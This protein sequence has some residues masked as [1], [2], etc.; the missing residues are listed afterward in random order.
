MS[1]LASTLSVVA[2]R[3]G[4]V[5]PITTGHFPTALIEKKV[6]LQQQPTNSSSVSSFPVSEN[7]KLLT[8]TKCPI[9]K[10]DLSLQKC[11]KLIEDIFPITKLVQDANLSATHTPVS[12]P[13]TSS[14]Q[15]VVNF[16]PAVVSSSQTLI[17]VESSSSPS[18]CSS[19]SSS[20]PSSPSE[21]LSTI[22]ATADSKVSSWLSPHANVWIPTSNTRVKNLDILYPT[23]K[24]NEGKVYKISDDA[25][26]A[27]E[28]GEKSSQ[29]YDIPGVAKPDF[30][31]DIKLLDN[32]ITLPNGTFFMD[33]ILPPPAT[34]TLEND[35]F[36]AT[37][38]IDLH[39]KVKD[40]GTYNFAG[41]RVELPHSKLNIDLFRHSLQDYDDKEV[42][43]F[44]Q[45]GFPLGLAEEIYLEPALK[46]HKS[47]YSY[48]SYLDQFLHKEVNKLGI[49]GPLSQ[50]PFSPTMLS[51][52]MT[53]PKNIASRRP[54]FDAS[55]GDWSL[56]ENTPVK[57]YM[58]GDYSFTFPTV[59]DLAD[60]IVKKGPGCLLWKRDLSR[61]FL[62]LPVDP[63]DYDK[64][65]FVWRGMF[66]WFVSYVWGCR[67]AGY[68]GQR[69][70]SAILFIFKKLGVSSVQP[71]FCAMVY[72]DDFAGCETGDRASVAFE[73]LGNL[74]PKLGI[75]ESED[76][77]Q[78]PSTT[79]KFLGVQF[80]TLSMSMKIDEEKLKEITMLSKTWSRKT[81]ATK[82]E[83]QSILGKLMWVSKVVR[84][85]RC[86]VSRIISI[87][88]GL[89]SQMQKITLSQEIK[90]DFLWWSEFLPVFNGVELLIPDTVFCSVLGDATLHG[91][92]SWN[93][94]EKEFF[95]RQFPL[96]LKSHKIYIH[97]KEFLIAIVATK[98][99]GHLWEGKRVAIYCD[100]EA[101]VKTMVYEKPQD[102]DL[103]KCLREM[104]FYACKFHFQPV[105]LRISTDDN[106]IADFIS[107]NY[108]YD[109]II[110][111]F[112]ARGL[113]NMK[114][115]PV[116]DD[117][118]DFVAD[119]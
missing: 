22:S 108:N 91:G 16:S 14:S 117:L 73:T 23:G 115:I 107:R 111:K 15:S 17:K 105:F 112:S 94:K 52:M 109:D 81:V 43:Q 93:E 85:S 11:N 89:R 83:L 21:P 45:F 25:W 31:N 99:W 79:M 86:F 68:N 92:G 61:W 97:I 67:H 1:G 30:G 27:L 77:A 98:L 102:T 62:Q 50:P 101:V 5:V 26:M 65:G 3:S 35:T 119:W 20:T 49:S 37:Y 55:W 56:N 18:S 39:K 69:V 29:D 57:S 44:L 63:A 104:L 103:Q 38:F 51:P 4:A 40:S 47:S 12:F 9:I 84:F 100:N 6:F 24:N 110:A 10:D 13:A 59:L 28:F 54:V 90:K 76:K 64:L 87:L 116:A 46:N 36:P 34:V 8:A 41:A 113:S 19:T 72:M 74:L 95:S 33:K 75:Q 66:W 82:Q 114:Q 80:D 118:F 71:E 58:G 88:K 70:S 106:D 78:A 53:S 42:C 96:H 60:L 7:Q 2:V 48:Y 32:K